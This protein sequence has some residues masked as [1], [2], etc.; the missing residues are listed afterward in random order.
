MNTVQP[1]TGARTKQLID[2][3]PA[4]CSLQILLLLSGCVSFHVAGEVERGRRALLAGQPDAALTSFQRAAQL[5]PAYRYNYSILRQGVWTYVGKAYYESGKFSE[6]RQALEK[7]NSLHKDDY[8]ANLYLGLVMANENQRPRALQEITAGLRRSREWL[9]YVQQYDSD[10]WLWDP[11]DDLRREIDK[12][13]VL[14]SGKNFSWNELISSG[15]RLGKKFEEQIDL[16]RRDQYY[17][18]IRDSD[19]ARD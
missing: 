16:V 2:F 19:D 4:V 12:N 14:V 17:E 9:D 1:K 10:G 15:E 18:Q 5:D 13:L 11:G 6:A 3:L 8:L 7:A